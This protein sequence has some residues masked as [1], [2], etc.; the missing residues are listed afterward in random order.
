MIATDHGRVCIFRGRYSAVLHAQINPEG[1]Q[2]HYSFQYLTEAAY[3]ANEPSDRFAG[4]LEAP[5]GGAELGS[6]RK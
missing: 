1:S 2:T 3:E 5:L 6:G 4:A